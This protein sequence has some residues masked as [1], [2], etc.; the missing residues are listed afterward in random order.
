MAGVAVGDINNDG[1]PDIYFTS[2]MGSDKLYLNKGK[3]QFQGHHRYSKTEEDPD[4][5]P[6]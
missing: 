1:L 2:N 5:K 4:G 3:L 6:E